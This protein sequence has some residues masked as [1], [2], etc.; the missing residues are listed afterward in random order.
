[1]THAAVFAAVLAA[2]YVAH[3]VGDHW[4]QTHHQACGKGAP[5][6]AGRMLCARHVATLTF[7]KVVVLLVTVAVTHLA[8]S[9]VA[10][11]A[12]LALD[13]ATHYVIDRRTPL[14]R[15]AQLLGKKGFHDLGDGMAAPTGTGAYALDQSLHLLFL[16]V[17][18]L[19][20]AAF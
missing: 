17:A 9:P 13:A 5:T 4:I 10:V 20:I 12:A 6:W 7:T 14:A 18:A 1:M 16:W 15:L 8:L 11:V 19:I 3:H 2:L